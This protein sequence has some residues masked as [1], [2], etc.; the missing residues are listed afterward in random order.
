MDGFY[1]LEPSLGMDIV[2]LR[3]AWPKHVW[4]GGL[5]GVDLMERGA[6]N[7]VRREVRRIIK[8]TDA[9]HSGGIFIDTS[10]EINPPIKPENFR[11]MIDAVGEMCN[12]DFVPETTD[13]SVRKTIRHGYP[14]Q[15]S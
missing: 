2:A 5:D 7:Q 4:A 12:P 14:S 3:N 8:E 15:T 1:C 10:S 6:P 9:L 11:A 13:L